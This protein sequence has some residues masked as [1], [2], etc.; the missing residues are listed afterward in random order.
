M[1]GIWDYTAQTWS[2][3][4]AIIYYRHI[5]STIQGLAQ[6]PVSLD[7]SYDVV[8]SGLLGYKAGHHIVICKKGKDGSFIVDRILHGKMDFQR[9][10]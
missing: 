2:E 10:Q 5:Y 6:L 7:R 8:K 3:D 9:H 1:D 4:Q